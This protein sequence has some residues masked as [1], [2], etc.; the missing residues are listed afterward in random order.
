M[1]MSTMHSLVILYR[2]ST[3]STRTAIIRQ[4]WGS[5]GLDGIETLSYCL[6]EPV[7]H[8]ARMADITAN[9]AC[10]LSR[11]ENLEQRCKRQSIPKGFRHEARTLAEAAGQGRGFLPKRHWEPL[12]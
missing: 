1:R 7:S 4:V 5:D 2:D 9:V 6:G 10:A 3:I 8:L 11:R 12:R